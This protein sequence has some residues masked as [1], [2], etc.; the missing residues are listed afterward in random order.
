[1]PTSSQPSGT[2]N[3][4]LELG[5]SN[6]SLEVQ[7]TAKDTASYAAVLFDLN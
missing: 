5:I 4:P 1:M 3:N 6:Q 2:K 7:T